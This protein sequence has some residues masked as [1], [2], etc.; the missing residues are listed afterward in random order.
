[1]V[2]FDEQREQ[3]PP[4]L[5]LWEPLVVASMQGSVLPLQPPTRHQSGTGNPSRSR[6]R[7]C[8][9][10]CSSKHLINVKTVL[11]LLAPVI[12]VFVGFFSPVTNT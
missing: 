12:V 9:L 10:S 3:H 6:E 8:L 5:N 2:L 7:N 1:M 4:S 11:Q